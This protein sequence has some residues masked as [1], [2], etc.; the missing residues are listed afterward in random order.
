MNL[1][2]KILWFEDEILWAKPL[3]KDIRA[4]VEEL[5]FIFSEPRFEKD[6]FNIDKINFDEFDIILMDYNLS[7]DEKGDIL[8]NK[9]REH[10]F[11]SEILFY[12]AYGASFLRKAVHDNELDGVHCADRPVNSFLP[13]V[14]EVIKVTVKK[15]L[16]LNTIRGIVMAET[17]DIDEKMLEIISLYVNKLET[18]DKTIFLEKRRKIFFESTDKKIKKTKSEDIDKFYYNWLFDSYQKWLTILDIVKKIKP[19]SHPLMK[20]YYDEIIVKRNRLAHVK[21]NRDSTGKKQLL[22]KEFVFNEQI[23]KEV[24]N[25]IKKHE[26]NINAILTFL[27]GN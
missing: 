23:G 10:N 24:L 25:N 4:F 16:D 1:E 22:D 9:I 17:S 11:F 5:G 15:V 18:K 27:K 19:E 12:S 20:L 3:I 26:K 6:N 2:Y 14:K 7:S 21:E 8:I 13:K